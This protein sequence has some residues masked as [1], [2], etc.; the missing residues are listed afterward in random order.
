MN[1]V[2]YAITRDF[3]NQYGYINLFGKKYQVSDIVGALNN[4]GI[5]YLKRYIQNAQICSDFPSKVKVNIKKES[6]K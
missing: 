2:S 6:R 5:P 3:P 4:T 1:L